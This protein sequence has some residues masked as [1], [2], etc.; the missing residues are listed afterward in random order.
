[1]TNKDFYNLVDSTFKECLEILKKK[2]EDYTVGSSD[3]LA[4]FKKAGEA[5][6][7]EP[8]K[9]WYIF[10][11]KHWQAITNYVRTGG[12]SESEPIEER[13]KDMLNY[14]LLLKGL[15]QEKKDNANIVLG[16]S[17]NLSTAI[18]SHYNDLGIRSFM[19]KLNKNNEST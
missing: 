7:L 14:L 18:K 6:E 15:I 11:N 4:N 1:M 12:Q 13:I 10:A 8:T 9:I 3:A 19:D 16:G 5:I 17:I 2:G